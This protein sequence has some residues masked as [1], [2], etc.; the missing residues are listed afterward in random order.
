MESIFCGNCGRKLASN[1]LFCPQCGTPRETIVHGGMNVVTFLPSTSP[2]ESTVV[3]SP[4]VPAEE[5]QTLLSPHA[6]TQKQSTPRK[7]SRWLIAGILIGLLLLVGGGLAVFFLRP[8]ST[9]SSPLTTLDA[10]C[11]DLQQHN[12]QG[13]YHYFSSSFQQAVSEPEFTR[14]FTGSTS[15]AYSPPQQAGSTATT[16]LT[17]SFPSGQ[18]TID[19]LTLQREGNGTWIIQAAPTLSTPART[20]AG[21]CTALIQ[22]QYH[23]AYTFFSSTYQKANSE[24]ALAVTEPAPTIHPIRLTLYPDGLTAREVEILRLVA[25]GWTDTQVAEKLI[26]SPRTVQGHLRSVYNKIDVTS[27]SAA[28]RYVVEHNLI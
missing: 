12:Y 5:Q 20:L 24:Q 8:P 13:G 3:S 22:G 7:R 19:S 26:I 2:D 25:L 11:H 6:V 4:Q 15:C 28:T 9:G 17:T 10:V 21:A 27:R 16:Q 23:I 14:Y 18:T 1:E